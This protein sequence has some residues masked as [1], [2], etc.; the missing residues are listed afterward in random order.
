[1]EAV[2]ERIHEEGAKGTRQNN[3][4]ARSYLPPS[5][6][7][8]LEL[9]YAH[10]P[11]SS[12]RRPDAEREKEKEDGM[13]GSGMVVRRMDEGGNGCQDSRGVLVTFKVH[14]LICSL[15]CSSRLIPPSPWRPWSVL[16]FPHFPFPFQFGLI[17][18]NL[19]RS[20]DR[21]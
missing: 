11:Q 6:I 19:P 18:S 17:P 3:L 4:D 12:M 7:I 2:V 10:V 1:M 14:S 9:S 21:S 13:I 5:T 20:F 8:A 15:E 16:S